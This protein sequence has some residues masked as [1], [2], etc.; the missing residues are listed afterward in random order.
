MCCLVSA[1]DVD[2]NQAVSHDNVNGFTALWMA[3][4]KG[5]LDVVRCL[6]KLRANVNQASSNGLT[7]LMAASAGQHEEVVVWL[8]KAGADTQAKAP[9][10]DAT[11]ADASRA[12]GASASQTAYLEAKTH[13]SNPSCSGAGLK[14]C[15]ACKQARYCGEPCQLAHWKAHK[16]DCKRWSAELAA[17]KGKGK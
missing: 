9:D 8:I 10:H 12:V 1:L 13:C 11:A 17:G 6:L 3:A 2:V 7:P 16:A 15:P 4:F 5:K 14:K